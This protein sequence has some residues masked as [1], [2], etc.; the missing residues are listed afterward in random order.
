MQPM[1]KHHAPTEHHCGW[2]RFHTAEQASVS[3]H[4]LKAQS[5]AVEHRSTAVQPHL[6]VKVI[7][8]SHRQKHTSESTFHE[9][10][11]EHQDI[12]F[13][14]SKQHGGQQTY[15]TWHN[16]QQSNMCSTPM[17]RATAQACTCSGVEHQPDMTCLCTMQSSPARC[18]WQCT[19]CWARCWET[20]GACM[21]FQG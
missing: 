20:A 16:K 8:K 2:A 7:T 14:S 5:H 4:Y 21:P 17:S 18:L 12:Q 19:T 13:S 6:S 10:F 15:P 9:L 3:F 11:H 1:L